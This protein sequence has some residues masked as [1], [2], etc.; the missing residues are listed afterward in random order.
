M[1]TSDRAVYAGRVWQQAQVDTGWFRERL[2]AVGLSQNELAA[3]LGMDKGSMSLALRGWRAIRLGEA[4]AVARELGV[5]VDEVLAHC[6]AMQ[7]KGGRAAGRVAGKK[8]PR[9]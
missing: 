2:A 3:R 9:G 1:A 5:E 6:G 4:V 8:K 7:G